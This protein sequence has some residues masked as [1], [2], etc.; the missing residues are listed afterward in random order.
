MRSSPSRTTAAKGGFHEPVRRLVSLL[1]E[2]RPSRGER[3]RS[4]QAIEGPMLQDGRR[5]LL[6]EQ[7][8]F[9]RDRNLAVYEP[10]V[11]GHTSGSMTVR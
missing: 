1:H 3:N 4:P 9:V 11:E 8:T 7:R 10:A 2:D 5:R 6:T